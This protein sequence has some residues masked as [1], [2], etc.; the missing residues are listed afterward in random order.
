MLRT[1]AFW[2]ALAVVSVASAAFAVRLFPSAFPLV[3]LEIAMDR[4]AALAAARDLMAS[5]GLGP[6]DYEQ[7]ASFAGDEEAQTFVELEGGGKEVLAAMLR[8]GLYSAY[9]WR[10]RHFKEAERHETL[11]RFR[12]DGRP[13][14]FVEQLE[15]TSAGAALDAEAA[16]A[17]AERVAR[18]SWQIDL[19][20]FALVEP[21]QERQPSGRVD[22]TF[23]YERSSPTLDEGRYRLRLVVSGDRLTEAT[24]FLQIPEAFR[25]RYQEM[26][27]ANDAIGIGASVA[28]IV[29]YVVGGIGGG[30]FFLLRHRWVLAR[31]AMR[32]G[33]VVA[34]LQVLASLSNWPLVWMQYDTAL[35]RSTFI[36]SQL[37][38]LGAS[39][40]GF[41][42]LF[43]LSFMA[44]ESL[45]R[46]A[47][48]HHVQLW[49]SWSAPLAA[50]K[51]ILG[52]T[53]A[54]YL[55]VGLFFAYEVLL[56][57]YA[58]RL[59]GWWSPSEALLHPDVLASYVPW[60]SAIANSLQAGF[61]EEALMRAVPIAG[62]ALI[63]DRFGKRRL[64][65][66]LAFVVQIAVFG[67]GHAP[68]ATQ[69]S[70]ARPVELIIP[71]IAFGLI[72]LWFGLLPGIIL[73]YAFDVV[74]FAIPLFVSTASGIWFDRFMV[75]ALTF[76]P[77]WIVFTA[78][79]R[80]RRWEEL[81]A[82]ALNAAWTPPPAVA[83][84]EPV[85]RPRPEAAALTGRVLGMWAAAGIAGLAAWLALAP[86]GTDIGPLN[87]SRTEAEQRARAALTARNAGIDEAWRV[88][89][90]PAAG[91]GG[92]HR[93]VWENADRPRFDALLGR[94]LATPHW[95]VRA[96]TFEGD[97]ASRAEEWTVLV[98]AT[99]EVDGVAH[100]LPESRDGA[101][102]AEDEARALALSA[103]RERYQLE[104]DA[105]REVSAGPSRRP[106]RT[107]WQF[108][109]VDV[110]VD[111][112]PLRDGSADPAGTASRGEARI[113][114][115]IAGDEVTSARAFVQVPEQWEREQRA[116]GTVAQILALLAVVFAAGVLL[117][118]SIFAIVA[119]SRKQFQ[120]RVGGAVFG[121]LFLLALVTLINQWPV[122]TAQLT[123]AQ[124][125]RLQL[126][127]LAVGGLLGLL[128]QAALAS[129]TA[130]ALPRW[131]SA[132]WG[133]M[134]AV[135]V[136]ASLGL[137]GLGVQAAVGALRGPAGPPWPNVGPLGT[138]L[139]LLA[140]GAGGVP[141][142]LL[143][144][145]TL[146]ALFAGLHHMTQAWT[147]RR[148]AF[149][150]LLVL[151]GLVLGGSTGE[152]GAATWL[153]AG[154][155]V[156]GMLLVAY[157]LALRHD[158][159]PTVVAVGTMAALAQVRVGLQ[160][161][162]PGALV[163]GLL[164][165][166]SVGVVTWWVFRLLRRA[167]TAAAE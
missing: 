147:T 155:P 122:L 69:P 106:A 114:V 113:D 77:L 127:V 166:V 11:I 84:P 105:L 20:P 139:P 137:I 72:Y 78:R 52:F 50:S 43:G 53:V 2:I 90:V 5:Q 101:S 112:I 135:I 62:A 37:A 86:F 97:V 167:H 8:E 96:A 24:H 148:A 82:D 76:V 151:A 7:A 104:P 88:M 32:W 123:T 10:V 12:P 9:T 54:G 44:A 95:R 120:V 68:Y 80:R 159:T 102:L 118:S 160:Q 22:H 56:Y 103:I 91:Y 130:G 18:E 48:P 136:G 60:L 27:S 17:I 153:L 100:A 19:A 36:A 158:M 73:H 41:S 47:F 134:P 65:I 162:I 30:L 59:F 115:Q 74:W 35:P 87:V 45:T 31:P 4:A 107:D 129:L 92:G 125:L 29:L 16:R 51:P 14:G 164:G 161:A 3:Q 64:F 26:R 38:T 94:Y 141:G 154:L 165:A 156:G 46:R 109:F 28:M 117:A 25:R 98:D 93:F 131:M 128:I 144:S 163:G 150:P 63:G 58:T 49:R 140:M 71:S 67:A 70:Y 42:L 34:L 116:Q 152:A 85:G 33:I 121:V 108:T 39:F 21:S 23:I 61:W 146:T 15:E 110:T 40:V 6:P 111:P 157:V 138:Y 66:V 13:Y 124:P 89:P 143:R 83:T 133:A 132:G 119:W 149:G 126:V 145:L 81:P 79:L 99:G 75:V 1:R 57:F 55:C 142:V